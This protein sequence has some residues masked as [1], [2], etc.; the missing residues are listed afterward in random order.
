MKTFPN[1]PTTLFSRDI[2]PEKP[3]VIPAMPKS[4]LA[5]TNTSMIHDIHQFF[6][7]IAVAIGGKF[8][9]FFA[10]AQNLVPQNW[11]EVGS[12]VLLVGGLGFACF[13]LWRALKQQ[14]QSRI[15]D[16]SNFTDFL[17]S[18]ITKSETSREKLYIVLDENSKAIKGLADKIATV[19]TGPV[20][21]KG[22]SNQDDE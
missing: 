3:R 12:T 8:I 14:I 2:P 20:R 1:T 7:G 11:W 17:K 4:L 22:R 16:Q 6:A 18:E 21:I 10:D 19:H 5:E 9:G 13:H 15:E